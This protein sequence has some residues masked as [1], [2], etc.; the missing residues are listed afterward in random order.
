MRRALQRNPVQRINVGVIRSADTPQTPQVPAAREQSSVEEASSMDV[1][2]EECT[3]GMDYEGDH[4]DY[5]E[6]L[7]DV[8][9]NGLQEDD[10]MSGVFRLSVLSIV[11]YIDNEV[12]HW[13]ND[14]TAQ[15]GESEDVSSQGTQGTSALEASTWSEA[16]LA[17]QARACWPPSMTD[18]IS[19]QQLVD[20][21]EIARFLESEELAALIPSRNPFRTTY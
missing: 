11:A 16:L 4:F 18:S 17:M 10:F 21:D 3:D 13:W 14:N 12:V 1:C 5:D 19:D 8:G 6:E 7:L 2:W 9:V 15:G 20:V